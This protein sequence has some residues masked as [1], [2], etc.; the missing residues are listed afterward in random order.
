MANT[1]IDS[2]DYTASTGTEW[3]DMYGYGDSTVFKDK[4]T[5]ESAES[6]SQHSYQCMWNDWNGYYMKVPE[7][8]AIID[9]KAIWTVGKGYK[10]DKKTAKILEKIRG[11]G[12]QTFNVIMMN[13]VKVYTICGDFYAE[14]IRDKRGELRNLK[15]LN[16]GTI[17]IKANLKGIISSYEQWIET[18]TGQKQA[19]V[20][21]PKDIFHLQWNPVADQIHGNSTISKLI[22]VIEALE[23]AKIDMRTVFHRYVKPLW[24]FSVDTDNT[25]EITAFKNKVDATIEKAE[26]LIVPKGTVDSIERVSI[27]QYS[28]LDPLPWIKNLT[29][30]FIRAEGVPGVVLGSTEKSA[31][32]AESKMLYLAFQQMVEWNQKFLEEQIKAQIGL[33]VEFEFPASIEPSLLEEQ[34]KKPS[35][36]S[37]GVN[38]NKDTK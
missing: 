36:K 19:V 8:S 25:A 11:N 10:T 1:K 27:P 5:I 28:N 22:Q 16:P 3:N 33:D 20:F 26:N 15:P 12:K 30:Q 34:S 13:A 17:K 37:E 35:V 31:S 14:I 38:P 18:P 24:V 6:T 23:E 2:T 7:L 9:R 4:L 29:E 21:S 32:E